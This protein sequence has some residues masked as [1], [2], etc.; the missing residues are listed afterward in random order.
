MKLE[1]FLRWASALCLAVSAFAFF[2]FHRSP[3]ALATANLQTTAPSIDWMSPYPVPLGAFTLNVY[4]ANFQNGSVVNWAG[5]PLPTTF[6]SSTQLKATGNATQSG[7]VYITVTNPGSPA[8]TSPQRLLEIGQGIVVTM[9]PGSATL[10][11]GATQQFTATVTGAANTGV[12]WYVN[13]SSSGNST[14]GTITQTGLYK[15]PNVPPATPVTIRAVAQVNSERSASAP[16]TIAGTPI[17]SVTISPT[18]ASV[19]TGTTRQFTAT[20][21]GSANTAVTWK[22]ADVVG[23]NSTVGT[24]S[25]T[26][27]YTAP[28]T[29]PAGAVAVSATSQ[30]D[31]TKK[32]TALVTV[33]APVSTVAV[34]VN[35]SAASLAVGATQQFTATVTGTANTA[36]TWRVNNVAGGDST[37]G[38]ISSNGLYAAPNAIPAGGITVSAVSQADATKQASA[39]VSLL[40]TQLITYG[41]FLDQS[42]FGPT[43]ALI[44]QVKQS[45]MQGFLNQQFALP[46]SALPNPSTATL[47]GLT[48][49][50]FANALGG[51]DQL[52][53]RTIFALS[54]V[55]VVARN[56][57]YNADMLT[58]WLRLLSRNAFGNYKTLLREL[59]NDSS[60]GQFL[61]LANSGVSGAANENYPRELLQ[62]FSIGLYKLNPD[63]SQQLD[64][65]GQPIPTYTQTDVQ[66]LALALTGWTYDNANH[67]T[68][69]SQGNPNYYAGPLVPI[70]GKHSTV[71]KTFLGQTLPANQTA[72]QDLDGAIDII[73]N[74]PNVG[75]FVATRMIRAMV[76]SNASAG[77]ISRVAAVFNNNGQ[78]VRGDMKAVIT[79]ILMDQE[80]RNDSVPANFG[81][82]RTPVQSL[83]FMARALGYP[84]GAGSSFNYQLVNLGEEMLNAP[85]VFGHYS[86]M[87]RIPKSNGLFGP[88]FQIYTPTEAANRANFLWGF[89]N[90]TYPINPALQPLV[91]IAASPA[92]LVNTV[93]NLLLYGRMSTAT[94]SALF[95]ALPQ[96]YDDRQRVHTALY[97]VLT[98]GE[99]LVQR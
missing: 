23:G 37:Y 40:D 26:G 3:A 97:L 78:G 35:P 80:A 98:S 46:E 88:E 81:R 70:P 74:H 66:Q 32:A 20:V 60:M 83:L 73:F 13:S 61:D 57:N 18:S 33:T 14:I 58:P 64:A 24:I 99:F 39:G 49:A 93:D 1:V 45:G 31:A 89:L 4:G 6:V 50:F 27:L 10:A 2:G 15:A 77:Y 65:N 62:L 29:V 44:A 48:D 91:D 96:M 75:P 68:P 19:Q 36:V 92:T 30:A 86:P 52:R 51:Q 22:V 7:S 82:L 11:P 87:F 21:S 8:V 72:Q 63:G 38:T 94:R 79:A 12:Y 76:T 71:A 95:N 90:N 84:V 25:S 69:G 55:I 34:S 42:T 56:K 85:S 9:S 67:T 17:V 47:N 59:S 53:Q 28:A 54:E 5:M 43:P 16:V 41:R